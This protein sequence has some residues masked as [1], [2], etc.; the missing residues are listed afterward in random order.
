MVSKT[1]AERVG[2]VRVKYERVQ[3]RKCIAD[4]EESETLQHLK[5]SFNDQ[6]L[7]WEL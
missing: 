3:I 6:F 4:Y 5:E 7:Q 2:L 1:R